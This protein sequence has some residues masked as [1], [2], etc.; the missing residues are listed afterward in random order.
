MKTSQIALTLILTTTCMIA[1]GCWK[2]AAKEAAKAVATDVAI[3]AGREAL[4][5][6][7]SRTNDRLFD[8]V[9]ADRVEPGTWRYYPF[10]V[11]GRRG[12]DALQLAYRLHGG[13]ALDFVLLTQEE[14][15]RIMKL[16][17]TTKDYKY[18]YF[19]QFTKTGLSGDFVSQRQVLPNGNYVLIVDNSKYFGTSPGSKEAAVYAIARRRS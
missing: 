18:N 2:K 3:D 1:A 9:P 19:P 10:T 4:D 11:Q 5:R 7:G 6:A 15:D 16:H 17:R 12:S 14:Y 8:N 13:P